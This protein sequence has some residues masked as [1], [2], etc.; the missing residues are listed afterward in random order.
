MCDLCVRVLTLVMSRPSLPQIISNLG[1][2]PLVIHLPIG[3]EESFSG[4][5]DLVKMKALVW[6]GEV[7]SNGQGS[8]VGG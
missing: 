5:V 2:N 8:G 1:A 7:R 3:Q 6:N 4:L